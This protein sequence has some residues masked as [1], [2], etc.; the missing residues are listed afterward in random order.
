MRK[1]SI[2]L[3]DSEWSLFLLLQAI[4]KVLSVFRS[5]ECNC[6]VMKWDGMRSRDHRHIDENRSLSEFECIT[7]VLSSWSSSSSHVTGV[8]MKQKLLLTFLWYLFVFVCLLSTISFYINFSVH[9]KW[10]DYARVHHSVVRSARSH[11]VPKTIGIILR[12]FFWILLRITNKSLACFI[13]KHTSHF[14]LNVI[15]FA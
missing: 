14:Q 1:C 13:H 15:N 5:I 8:W 4:S 12:K 9:D 7:F 11:I 10:R 2:E 6:D 3:C